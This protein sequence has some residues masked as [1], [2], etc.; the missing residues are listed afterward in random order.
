MGLT[1]WIS[2]LGGKL[3]LLRVVAEGPGESGPPKVATR[4]VTL[5]ELMTEVR[6]PDVRALVESAHGDLSKELA[7]PFE[8]VF[9][10]AGVK[11]PAHGWTAD[12]L[13]KLVNSDPY[14]GMSREAA[15]KAILAVLAAD[16][17]TAEEV[18]KDALA[19]D[20]AVDAFEAS[21]T[22][23][24]AGRAQ[25]RQRRADEIEAEINLLRQEAQRLRDQ[26]KS[27]ED[28]VRQWRRKKI[29][30]EKQLAAALGYLI[31]RPPI[32]VTEE[33]KE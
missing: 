9:E 27:E 15:Q 22:Q 8:Q 23:E 7:T 26:T 4:S 20:A 24:M 31:E 25:A 18:L 33:G 32:S 3:G 19:R 6:G 29:D 10:A 13:S 11:P 2:G 5:G 28:Q 17:A 12:R 16:K 14:K 30:Y 1:E 21:V